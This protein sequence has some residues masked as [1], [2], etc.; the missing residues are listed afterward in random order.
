MNILLIA[1]EPPLD[2]SQVATGNAIR[3]AQLT[4]CLVDA[5]HGVR[6]VWMAAAGE[7]VDRDISFDSR[8][9]LRDLLQRCGP[10]AVLV[11]Y[12]ELLDLFPFDYPAPVILDFIAPRPLEDLFEN[13][14]LVHHNLHR[15]KVNL[16]KA[17]LLLTGNEAQKNLLLLTLLEGRVDL[18]SEAGALVVPLAARPA[19]A[20]RSD[21]EESGWTLVAGGVDWPWRRAGPYIEALEAP[22]AE[23]ASPARLI[24]F[25]GSYRLHDTGEARD[26]DV[27][28]LV[29][30]GEYSQWL[31]DHAHIGL[32]L[33]EDNVERRVSQSF[34]T[35]DFLRHGLP[36]VCNA[37]LPIADSIGRFDAGW[38][39]AGPDE[40]PQL[41]RQ[42]LSDPQ[43]WRQKSRNAARL[44]GQELDP[45]RAGAPLLAWLANAH[46]ARR[47]AS[48]PPDPPA[49]AVP[50]WPQRIKR[51]L[52][53]RNLLPG[54]LVFQLQRK[55]FGG[56]REQGVVMVSR[57]DLF[58]ADHGAAV[59][60][61][62]TARG[63]SRNGRPVALVTDDRRF[64]WQLEDG[65]L[66]RRRVP[67]W[68]RLLS[69]PGILS[70]ALHYSKD[71]PQ[72]NAFLYLPLT[73]G[74]FFWR[75]LYAGRRVGA[76]VLQAEFPAYVR[77][78]LPAGRILDAHVVLVQHNVEYARIRAQ[79]PELTE[80]QYRRYR[81]IEI[82]LCNQC[83]AVI[84]VSDNDR[85]RLAEDG[86]RLHL[87]HTIPHGV[88]LEGFRQPALAT[89]RDQFGIAADATLLVYHGTYAYWPNLEALQVFAD[90][91]LPRLDQLGLHCHVLAIGRE[92]PA[93]SPH[94]RIHLTGSVDSI[95][96]WLKAADIAVVPLLEGGGTRMKII[97]CFAAHLPL[98]S[99]SKGI[100]GIPVVNG[101]EALV[102]DDWDA[103]A[104]AIVMLR[105]QPARAGALADA[106]RQLAMSLDWKAI[107]AR[108]LEL[109]DGL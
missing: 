18:R 59:K 7:N 51:L 72:S 101:R 30:Y 87:L 49:L 91:L 39:V 13:P 78:C 96:P 104:A 56:R 28:P 22:L 62:E 69:L 85:Q 3:A 41:L 48:P 53:I 108:Y 67:F 40:L 81:A 107:A 66:R 5:G 23:C 26:P 92:P 95:A 36:V 102:I 84:C 44:A 43:A 74:S 73:D 105:Q 38:L 61:V 93:T 64:W 90:E 55:L 52:N 70:K 109:F 10:D 88:D 58:P 76:A 54:G 46:K 14:G 17:D 42:I 86:V 99:T 65:Q 27:K 25:G 77:P 34:R 89:V 31:L 15:L 80:E 4:A 24:R 16:S 11:S 97:D 32:E 2:D 9:S 60:I 103:M 20:P 37:Y 45:D 98:I 50:P 63:L 12:W 33:A 106:G 21:P 1:Q 29:P 57:G 8:D 83:A 94:P 100:E 35:L 19:G 75:T 71:I 79:V 68:V 6:H 82:D 47:F